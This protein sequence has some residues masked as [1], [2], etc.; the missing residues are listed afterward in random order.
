V[1]SQAGN[2]QFPINDLYTYML[3]F[4]QLV[5]AAY[6][7]GWIDEKLRVLQENNKVIE[8]LTTKISLLVKKSLLVKNLDGYFAGK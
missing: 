6:N 1:N 8:K 3:S 7:A 5:W 2:L 4:E